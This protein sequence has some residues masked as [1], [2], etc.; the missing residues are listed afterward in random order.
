VTEDEAPA[1]E[2]A[3]EVAPG[4][5]NLAGDLDEMLGPRPVFRTQ[6][7][8]YDRLQVDNYAAWAESEL[9][10]TRREVDE[11]LSRYGAAAAE[12]EIS[13]RQLAEASRARVVFP[14]SRRI[15]EILRL[16]AD[17]AAAIT[18]A[19]AQ[20]ADRLVAE[21]RT[22]AD[23]RLRK[24][25]EIKEMAVASAD[26]LREQARRERADATADRERAR[27]DAEEILRA[28]V[29]ERERLD[30]E[31]AEKRRRADR[32]AN[33]QLLAV[34]EK[35]D[36]LGRQRDEMRQFLRGLADR[37]GQALEAVVGTLPDGTAPPD[38]R[39]IPSVRMVDN[40]VADPSA[41]GPGGKG[42]AAEDR[43]PLAG[44]PQAVRS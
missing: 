30:E 43:D 25:Q 10:T 23:A 8:G 15:E 9:V 44:R 1:G 5:P 35:V 32:A 19:G 14:V 27:T 3:E 20:E 36:T 29:G 6:L 13:R 16:A 11:L 31:A 39:A 22:E 26:E 37:V 17:E 2:A 34:Q 38:Q 33:A 4:R 21:A 42:S 12:L 7:H 28:A 41:V 40:I 18:E 24:A